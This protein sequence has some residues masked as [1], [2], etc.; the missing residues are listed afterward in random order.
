DVDGGDGSPHSTFSA[1][2]Q[3]SLGSLSHT[4]ADDTSGGY[5]VTVKV[6]DKDGGSDAKS[7]NVDVHNVAPSVTAAADQSSDEGASHSFSLGSFSDPGANDAP[8]HA[9]VDWG[10]GHSDSFDT[11]SQ[12]SLGSL[13][14]TYADNGLYSVSVT[15]TDKDGASGS[16]GFQVTVHNVAPS[17]TAAADQSSNE[18]ENHSFG[19]GTFSDP[20][21]GDSPWDVHVNWGDGSPVDH[22]AFSAQ[23]SL[24]ST[25]HTYDD[26]G[27]YTVTVTVTDKDG[28]SGSAHFGVSVANVAPTA[29]LANDGPVGEGSP[30]TISFSN[31]HD[32]SNAD[33]AAGFHYAYACGG[34]SLAGSNYGNS[35]GSASTQCT[36]ADNGSYLV[37]A[38]IID[39]NDG[40]TESTTTVAVTNV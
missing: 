39:K 14:H 24:G 8:W 36:F 3:G 30:A 27:S 23:G 6:T 2:A 16:A 21:V 5:T 17:V 19:L 35:G 18:G 26:N 1:A 20:G 34:G 37:R 11:S 22:L 12:G 31:Q 4:Y 15:V 10:D 7:F 32:P 33:T 13:S 9:S 29:D 40:F 38:R 25:S 28:A